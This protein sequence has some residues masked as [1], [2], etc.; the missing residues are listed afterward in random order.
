VPLHLEPW[1]TVFVVFRKA[2]RETAH[3]LPKT[4]L[5]S[6]TSVEGPWTVSFQPD[7][8]APASVQLDKLISWSDSTNPGV[9]CFSGKGTYTKTLDAPAS[10]FTPAATLW[11]DLGEV[12]NLA[13]TTVNGKQ[14]PTAWHAPY[15]VD[16]TQALKPDAYQISIFVIDSWF[17]RLIGDLQPNV[18]T[19]Y[20]FITWPV[21]KQ[22]SPL[23][24]S[25][26]IGPVRLLSEKLN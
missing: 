3:A 22:D 8:A 25:G 12:S 20:T 13:L 16:V 26:L 4:T 21:Y 18:K 1:G 10:W 15:R 19:K 6:L 14:L 11:L 17:N 24:S 23:V 5:A 2:T 9:K 7:R